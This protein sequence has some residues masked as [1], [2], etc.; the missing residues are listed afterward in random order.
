MIISSGAGHRA[1]NLSMCVTCIS[2]CRSVVVICNATLPVVRIRGYL[3]LCRDVPLGCHVLQHRLCNLQ[4][5]S[6]SCA[7]LPWVT[8][9]I[10][11]GWMQ[12]A[13]NIGNDCDCLF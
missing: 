9:L 12:N 10:R 7:G 1:H 6:K 5:V 11:N 2:A 8:K 13:W 4:N 3:C